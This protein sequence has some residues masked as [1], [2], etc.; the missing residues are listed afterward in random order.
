MS[1]GEDHQVDDLIEHPDRDGARIS[2]THAGLLA[3][4]LLSGPLAPLVADSEA[5]KRVRDLDPVEVAL[6]G[7]AYVLDEMDGD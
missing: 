4:A 7:L 6:G 1:Y 5:A 3:D 2:A